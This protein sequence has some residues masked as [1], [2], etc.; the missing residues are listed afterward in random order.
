MG[1]QVDLCDL[2]AEQPE[3]PSVKKMLLPVLLTPIQPVQQACPSC[4]TTLQHLKQSSLLSCPDCYRFFREPLL[5]T[6][7]Q[8]HGAV[9]HQG[10]RPTVVPT[11]PGQLRSS[12]E[13]QLKGLKETLER[14]VADERYE[15]AARARDQIRA[16][17]SAS[18]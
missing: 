3:G 11:H 5:Q 17:Q 18:E 10:R 4:R 16:I 6:L 7:R 13:D 2:C 1:N 15:D 12:R 8:L 14:A 9:T